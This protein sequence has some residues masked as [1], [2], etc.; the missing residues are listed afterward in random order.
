MK[1][2]LRTTIV[3]FAIWL[4]AAFLNAILDITYITIA[5]YGKGELTE[6]FGMVLI[7]SLLFSIPGIL[8][9]W[10]VYLL[11]YQN[12]KLFR[13][14]VKTALLT[15]LLSGMIFF[16]W[17]SEGFKGHSGNLVILATFAAFLSV[18]LHFRVIMNKS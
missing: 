6:G 3:S 13:L 18:S 11:N 15:S 4:A 9:F 12:E 10:I 16:I 5:G 1:I 17:L 2:F 7:V 8:I 14:L